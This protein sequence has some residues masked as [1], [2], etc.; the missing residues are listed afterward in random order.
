[1]NQIVE[2][3]RANPYPGRIVLLARSAALDGPLLAG[4]ALT[5]RSEA[6]RQRRMELTDQHTL[7]VAP[8]G[9]QSRDALRHYN[10]AEF[11]P[12]FTVYGNGEQVS[13]VAQR[14]QDGMPPS[15]ALEAQSY[16]P[17]PPIY[18][19]RITVVV[20]RTDECAWFGA[21]RRSG[22][23][24]TNADVSILAVGRLAPGD[25][26]LLSTYRSDG[27][28]VATAAHHLE[29]RTEANE[30]KELLDDL[31]AGLDARFR[32]AA[33]VFNPC[34]SVAGPMRVL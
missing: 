6:S 14:L 30:P 4:Y 11:G 10:A 5:G 20:D 19:P 25:L 24:R 9:A 33:T 28:T 8:I 22:G 18:T 12:R 26:V 2:A 1:M 13:Q 23:S 31:W 21:A 7:I 27:E 29:L 17:D 3:L 32:I 16:E 15:T 34:D